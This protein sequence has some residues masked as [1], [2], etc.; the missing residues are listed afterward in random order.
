MAFVDEYDFDVLRNES[1]KL[2]IE[3]LEQQ[4]GAYTNTICRCNECVVDMAAVA[5]NTVRPLYRVSLL[6]A[7]YAA[8][9]MNE[10]SYAKSLKDAVSRAIERVRKNPSHD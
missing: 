9:A 2:V 7:Q 8:Q 4:L 10:T 5:L 3:E 6:G 1:E